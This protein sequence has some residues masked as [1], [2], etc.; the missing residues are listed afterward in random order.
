MTFFGMALLTAVG[1]VVLAL[2]AIVTAWYARKAFL[3]QSQEVR[4]IERQA[5]DGQELIRQQAQLINIQDELL[6]QQRKINDLQAE[7][8]HESLKER[9]RL[10]QV[11]ERQ[12]ANEIGFRMTTTPFPRIPEEDGGGDEFAVDADTRVHMAVVS[13][14]SRRPIQNVACRIGRASDVDDFLPQTRVE[15]ALAVLAGRLSVSESSGHRDQDTILEPSPFFS[16]LRI[17]PGEKYGFVFEINMHR[18]LELTDVAVRFTDDNGMQW[19]VDLDQHLK[20][21]QSRDW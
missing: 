4:A 19:Q 13:N 8:L 2:F 6:K 15:S 21:L 14:E 16:S 9:T 10:R 18:P 17:R 7:D 3:R 12:Q 5:A 20:Q 1:T 11:A